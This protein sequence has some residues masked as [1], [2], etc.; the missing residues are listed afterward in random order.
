M[1]KLGEKNSIV[2]NNYQRCFN[3]LSR[4]RV[5]WDNPIRV[6]RCNFFENHPMGWDGREH[7]KNHPV[8]WDENF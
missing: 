6:M 1:N 4:L 5:G 2:F 7:F 8:S 3:Q